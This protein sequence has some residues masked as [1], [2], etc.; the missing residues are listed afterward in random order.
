R[1]SQSG[2]PGGGVGDARKRD[3]RQHSRHDAASGDAIHEPTHQELAHD[4]RNAEIGLEKGGISL[5]DAD[6]EQNIELVDQKSSAKHSDDRKSD[7]DNEKSR[8]S[9]GL[10]ERQSMDNARLPSGMLNHCGW[11]L[12]QPKH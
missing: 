10:L 8:G 6:L 7:R 1:Q 12:A 5:R 9:N 11:A 3:E 4:R 2:S